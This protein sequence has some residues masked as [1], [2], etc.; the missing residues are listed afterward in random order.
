MKSAFQDYLQNDNDGRPI[1]FI[2]H[3]QGAAMLIKL[4]AQMVDKA[5]L[6]SKLV[7]AVILGGKRRSGG[8]DH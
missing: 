6:R 4:L 8:P 2:G 7:M 1:V 3:S 5:T